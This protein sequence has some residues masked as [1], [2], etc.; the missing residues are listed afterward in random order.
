MRFPP[1]RPSPLIRDCVLRVGRK[2][3]DYYCHLLSFA[4]HFL[5]HFPQDSG[6]II[7][8]DDLII[9][10]NVPKIYVRPTLW[11][12]ENLN[13]LDCRPLILVEAEKGSI[14]VVLSRF[15]SRP[16]MA[17]PFRAAC[18]Q[19]FCEL[20][21]CNNWPYEGTGNGEANEREEWK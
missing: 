17:V 16:S 1:S 14:A 5:P 12:M 11:I 19:K 18:N 20:R 6:R 9:P 4:L 13:S 3:R 15:R 2:R 10:Y 8:R 7:E 21:E